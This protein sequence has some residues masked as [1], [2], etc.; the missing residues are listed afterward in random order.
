MLFERRAIV[1]GALILLVN[2]G[3][4]CITTFIALHAIERGVPTITPYFV[5]YAIV[6]LLS[7][8]FIGRLIDLY[9]YRLPAILS[10]LC[11]AATLVLIGMAGDVAAFAGAGVLGGLGLGT[12][13]GTY[14]AMAVASVEP[15]RRGVATSTYMTAFD[16]GIAIG[17][18]L[19]GVF[20]GAFG[21]ELMY[22]AS[23]VFPLAAC[24]LSFIA[25]K[26]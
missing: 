18:L 20:A 26:K 9:G 17:S 21:Y 23:A 22:Y 10:T 11:T 12:A 25:V 3:F 15:R 5:V 24:A 1:P 13:M 2:I 6:T 19:G 8:P 16:L 7:R 4:G 14:Q